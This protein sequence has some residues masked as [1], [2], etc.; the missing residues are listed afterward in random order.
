MYPRISRI[1]VQM[2]SF[3]QE[4]SFHGP[5]CVRDIAINIPNLNIQLQISFEDANRGLST[6]PVI[7]IF[8]VADFNLFGL[9]FT[10]FGQY[11]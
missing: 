7:C 11:I 8:I 9:M 6:T 1:N 4:R 3:E 10:R 2:R 5:Q